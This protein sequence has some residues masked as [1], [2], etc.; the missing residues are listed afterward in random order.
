MRNR[1]QYSICIT[2]YKTLAESYYFI[3]PSFFLLYTL[4]SKLN[5]PNLTPL[6][7]TFFSSDSDS[8]QTD[9]NFVSI[10]LRQE[11]FFCFIGQL[12]F[13]KKIKKSRT[14]NILFICRVWIDHIILKATKWAFSE[15]HYHYIKM[16]FKVKRLNIRNRVYNN[17]NTD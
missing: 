6:L 7:K 1:L 10:W 8:N 3:R 15:H 4:I 16:L 5:Q 2:I 12:F 13:V 9:S 17:S 14:L 11:P